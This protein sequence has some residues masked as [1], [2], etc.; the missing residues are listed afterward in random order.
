MQGVWRAALQG[1]KSRRDDLFIETAPLPFP[2]Y[3]SSS[4]VFGDEKQKISNARAVDKQVIPTG[5]PK[6]P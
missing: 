3:F 4:K 5:F 2:F 6:T 1:N